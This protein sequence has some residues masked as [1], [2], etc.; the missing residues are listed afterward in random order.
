MP[1]LHFYFVILTSTG[2]EKF[3]FVS[4]PLNLHLPVIRLNSGKRKAIKI[5]RDDSA[6]YKADALP[7]GI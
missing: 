2:K 3:N 1:L 6:Q 5:K 4:L 7:L